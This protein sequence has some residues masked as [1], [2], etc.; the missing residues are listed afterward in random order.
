MNHAFRKSLFCFFCL[1][2]WGI[3]LSFFPR[4]IYAEEELVIEMTGDPSPAQNEQTLWDKNALKLTKLFHHKNK[5]DV[6]KVINAIPAQE[7]ILTSST[8]EKYQLVQYGQDTR[9]YRKFVFTD[10]PPYPFVTCA[11]TP[12]DIVAVYQ[13][14]GVNLGMR[15][16]DFTAAYPQADPPETFT[17]DSSSLLIYR[18]SA[19]QL[20]LPDKQPLF[21]VFNQNKLVEFLTGEEALADYKKEKQPTIVP[22]K[23]KPA[24]PAQPAKK[25]YKALVSGGTLQDRMYMP[26]VIKGPFTQPSNP[27]SASTK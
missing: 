2:L 22:S 7:V 26:R 27:N 19:N 15:K 4:V 10:I 21:A 25:P 23:P 16:G 3:F 12:Q 9:D 20:P 24:A 1:G 18:L 17:T 11:A 5:A 8:G 13:R 14:Y 6:L